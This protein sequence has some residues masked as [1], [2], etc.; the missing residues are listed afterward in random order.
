MFYVKLTSV[1]YFIT[2][3]SMTHNVFLTVRMISTTEGEIAIHLKTPAP[4]ELPE[5]LSVELCSAH[6]DINTKFDVEYNN[7]CIEY[8]L[9][10][11]LNVIQ[12]IAHCLTVYG[13][14]PQMTED[15]KVIFYRSEMHSIIIVTWQPMQNSWSEDSVN[16]ALGTAFRAT[17]RHIKQP[18][19]Y[20]D[21]VS[22]SNKLVLTVPTIESPI[23]FLSAY[24]LFHPVVHTEKIKQII[25]SKA[26]GRDV[27]QFK[28]FVAWLYLKHPDYSIHDNNQGDVKARTMMFPVRILENIH[29]EKSASISHVLEFHYP[30]TMHGSFLSYILEALYESGIIAATSAV[31]FLT[32]EN[33]DPWPVIYSPDKKITS[34][35]S[36]KECFLD[37]HK[38]AIQTSESHYLVDIIV[39]SH[40]GNN[41]LIQRL[42]SC[43]AVFKDVHGQVLR[44]L[45]HQ[46]FTLNSDLLKVV[47]FEN[48]DVKELFSKTNTVYSVSKITPLT[49]VQH[50]MLKDLIN[51]LND[52]DASLT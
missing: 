23:Q 27:E 32:F 10:C 34:V 8:P 42:F 28:K 2:G 46:S 43:S 29:S 9:N 15:Q 6:P 52:P 14:I 40:D 51:K 33:G 20:G 36:S 39:S 17:N 11:N 31:S 48:E 37:A 35:F 30:S 13:L 45:R 44:A 16:V 12:H 18:E 1:F 26:Q 25:R 41:I 24:D 50:V 7:V 3:H 5:K 22:P 49:T 38:N 47:K 21:F 19:L 4:N